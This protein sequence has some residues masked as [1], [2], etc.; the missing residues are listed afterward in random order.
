MLPVLAAQVETFMN[1]HPLRFEDVERPLGAHVIGE[2]K[3]L[4]QRVDPKLVESLLAAPT[5]IPPSSASMAPRTEALAPMIGLEDFAKVDL[6]VAKIID[7]HR[8][9]GADK[10]L[11]LIL[12]AG[13]HDEQGRPKMRHVLR[14]IQGI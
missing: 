1:L 9:E 11:R 13:E 8:V 14:G 10:L 5:P 4:M 3:H 2:Y 6:R 7:C 12:D